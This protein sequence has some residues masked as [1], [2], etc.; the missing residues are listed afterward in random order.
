MIAP[1]QLKR[2]GDLELSSEAVLGENPDRANYTGQPVFP[3]GVY[4]AG[5]CEPG[6]QMLDFAVGRDYRLPF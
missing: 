5:E 3:D 1:D 4:T 2:T 6:M